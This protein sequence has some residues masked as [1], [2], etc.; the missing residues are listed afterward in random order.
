MG[1]EHRRDREFRIKHFPDNI[2]DLLCLLADN[3]DNRATIILST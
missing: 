3:E 1:K 2:R